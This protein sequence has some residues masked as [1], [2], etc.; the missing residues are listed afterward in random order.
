[1]ASFGEKECEKQVDEALAECTKKH[2]LEAL[3]VPRSVRD[4][5]SKCL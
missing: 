5:N 4:L 1:M 3:E 2:L